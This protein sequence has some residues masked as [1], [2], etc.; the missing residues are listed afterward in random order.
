MTKDPLWCEDCGKS[1]PGEC[2][3]HG[4]LI[5]V[6]DKVIPSHARLTIPHY[7]ALK[8]I[9]LRAGNQQILG[10]YARK[11]IQKRT[12]FGPFLAPR[13][14][15]F[16]S[17]SDN[18]KLE[19]KLFHNG[20]EPLILDTSS[21][22]MCNWMMFVRQASSIDDQNVVAYQ[23]KNDIYFTTV[24]PIPPHSELKVWYAAEYAKM[25]SSDTLEKPC[26]LS[27]RLSQLQQI[28]SG[29]PLPEQILLQSPPPLP[30]V[31]T[32][33]FTTL[34]TPLFTKEIK[35]NLNGAETNSTTSNGSS[36]PWKCSNCNHVFSTF[37]LLEE[38]VCESKPT[39][40]RGRRPKRGKNS[41]L[42]QRMEKKKETKL[43]KTKGKV[44]RMITERKTYCCEFCGKVFLN[45]EKLKTHS[46]N[47]T[48]ERPFQCA[49][50]DCKKAFVS[51]YKLMRHMATH[52]PLKVHT[53]T[54]CD[55]KFHRK[56]H[57]KNHL[58]THDPNKVSF[59][60]KECGKVY[61]TKPGF[62]KHIA[63]HA[64]AAGDL[65]CKI[66][67]KDFE[68]TDILL[69]H[70]KVHSGKSNGV[71][72]K[73]HKCEHCERRFYTRKDV[74]R[75]LVVHTG[76]K[77]FL[78][79]VCG[80]RFGRKDH[81]VRHSR[82]SHSGD[83]SKNR[84]TPVQVQQMQQALLPITANDTPLLQTQLPPPPPQQPTLQQIQPQQQQIQLQLQPLPIKIPPPPP[85]LIN[86]LLQSPN[87]NIT[88]FPNTTLVYT[89]TKARPPTKAATKV[90]D[91]KPPVTPPKV[92]LEVSVETTNNLEENKGPA[93]I[94]EPVN[95][96]TVDLGQ[97]LGFLPLNPPVT[98]TQL[99]DPSPPP[100]APTTVMSHPATLTLTTQPTNIQSNGPSSPDGGLQ[101]LQNATLTQI[102]F[103]SPLTQS[104]PRFHQA[105]Q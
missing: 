92:A 32:A 71:K 94:T 9:E 74:R 56:D 41:A 96:S 45:P 15:K 82:K 66:C 19:F 31:T 53:C 58:H 4:P 7:L 105:F 63:L 46:Y 43:K 81:L 39:K 17:R 80:Q 11:L 16:E 69:E 57:L 77:D 55:K 52:S 60:C 65:T 68:S 10:I 75:H 47:H 100:L 102:A 61:N 83:A 54:Y 34:T 40:K 86:K 73:K 91:I 27:P 22:D 95:A 59:N 72:E 13:I 76:R 49:H 3:I 64:A 103:S 79:Q 37:A 88:S 1:Q 2:S 78:C 28:L 44:S 29:D 12:Q 93:V 24:K 36:D 20:L 101:R 67:N 84:L 104:L 90:Y 35:E 6:K 99:Q 30:A 18:S 85:K 5:K 89:Q 62:R 51:K 8:E 42:L 33:T 26:K 50:T 48:G 97:L 21:E 38:H 14:P 98:S 25:M 87:S 70:I 23:H